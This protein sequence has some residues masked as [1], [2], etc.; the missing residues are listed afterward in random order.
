[1]DKAVCG[2]AQRGYK[3]YVFE[4]A[5]KEL[6]GIALPFGEWEKLGV[7]LISFGEVEKYL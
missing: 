2:L 1:V 4:D 7:S 5:I 3:V 6:P